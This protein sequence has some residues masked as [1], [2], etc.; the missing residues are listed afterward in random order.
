[1]H[2]TN[3]F[4]KHLLNILDKIHKPGIVYAH[5]D[6]PC[7]IYDPHLAQLAAH[8]VLRM[9]NLIEEAQ[10]EMSLKGVK[11]AAHK[12]ARYT[13]VKE[14]HSELVKKEVRIIWG[15]YFKPEHLEKY[16]NLHNLVFE[17]MKLASKTKQEVNANA[18]KELLAKVQE[19]AEIFFKTKG[20]EPIRIKTVYPTQG[21]IVSYNYK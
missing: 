5:C 12:I 15:D 19:F 7:G 1:M 14:E 9:T 10:V 11:E 3:T 21:E 16:P 8:T 18:A 17:I 6:I 13:L 4:F 20:V 2:Q